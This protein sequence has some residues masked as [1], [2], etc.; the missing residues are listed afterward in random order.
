MFGFFDLHT[1][2]CEHGCSGKSEFQH[3]VEIGELG[4]A[5]SKQRTFQSVNPYKLI[6]ELLTQVENNSKTVTCSPEHKQVT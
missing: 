6:T 4:I 3:G 5:E 2:C 1:K